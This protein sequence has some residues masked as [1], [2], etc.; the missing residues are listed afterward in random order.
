MV[1]WVCLAAL[2]LVLE[3][4]WTLVRAAP[5][6]LHLSL[7]VGNRAW[8]APV[9][10][11]ASHPALGGGGVRPRVAAFA[12]M[13]DTEAAEAMPEEGGEE[14]AVGEL[15]PS[16]MQRD[17]PQAGGLAALSTRARQLR[18]LLRANEIRNDLTEAEFALTLLAVSSLQS[19]ELE[20]D[21]GDA[22]DA[23]SVAASSKGTQSNPVA[24]GKID[25]ETLI[26]KLERHRA[27]LED[28]RTRP[29]SRTASKQTTDQLDDT[30]MRISEINA[31]LQEALAVARQ[32]AVEE[33]PALDEGGPEQELPT[34]SGEGARSMPLLGMAKDKVLKWQQGIRSRE[35]QAAASKEAAAAEQDGRR[36]RMDLIEEQIAVFVRDDGTVDVDA[37]IETGRE[38]ARFSAE[39][40]ERLN[41]K[42]PAA[43][44]GGAPEASMLPG[45]AGGMPY[46]EMLKTVETS[47]QVQAA[48]DTFLQEQARLFEARDSLAAM[49]P[50]EKRGELAW[51]PNENVSPPVVMSPEEKRRAIQAEKAASRRAR[52][53]A[54]DLDMERCRRLIGCEIEQSTSE[55]WTTTWLAEQRRLVA[56]FGLLDAQL[57]VLLGV[58]RESGDWDENALNLIDP[59]ELDVVETQ[60]VELVS[61]VGGFMPSDPETAATK[62]T[63][64]DGFFLDL[65][66]PSR[67]QDALQPGR[68]NKQGTVFWSKLQAGLSFYTTGTR[69]LGDDL[70][71]AVS[72]LGKAVQGTTLAPREARTLRR[73]AKDLV[74][75]VPFVIILLIPLSPVGHVL[76]FSFIQRVFPDFM[77]STYTERRQN[78][79]KLYEAISPEDMEEARR[80][81]KPRRR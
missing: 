5:P 80:N 2:G 24:S 6:V 29:M 44:G 43:E 50:I 51:S 9:T 49:L 10:A 62:R 78:L 41:G 17:Q 55:S 79:M 31:R 57:T 72:L 30:L 14:Q 75:L 1:W 18:E 33:D 60:I 19:G 21:G 4:S 27:Y 61:R 73:T 71:Y 69:L 36:S 11:R 20:V 65:I 59:D 48:R 63:G 67:W 38:V 34:D 47:P 3:S 52:L 15:F 46:D 42:P 28:T 25:L 64:I 26:A 74:T 40:W 13:Q 77:P 39:L 66:D 70:N 56:E 54:L 76:V 16:Y 12:T 68:L 81:I 22:P 37:A 53:A 45:E 8:A 23:D 35:E 7:V 32:A 58:L